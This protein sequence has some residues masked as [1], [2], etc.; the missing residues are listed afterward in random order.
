MRVDRAELPRGAG[1]PGEGGGRDLERWAIR[2]AK[3]GDRD[4]LHYLYSHYADDMLKFV[5][6][7]VRNRHDAEDI[8]QAVFAK[9]MR[10]IQKYEEREVPFAVWIRRVARNAA[11]DHVRSRRQ[12]PVEEV[13]ISENGYEDTAFEYLHELKTALA[14]LPESQR[15]VLFLRYVGGLSPKEIAERLG[16]TEASVHGLNHRGSAA[17][18]VWLRERG[19][20]P[21]SSSAAT[22]AA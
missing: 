15:Q 14:D 5:Q 19:V 1:R 13:R 8:T 17:L 2:A 18:K 3:A 4:A 6:S 10:A 9:L 11:L 7:I 12:I 21:S 20:A 16:K 22:R